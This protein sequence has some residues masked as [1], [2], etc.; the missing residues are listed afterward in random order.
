MC[1][2]TMNTYIIDPLLYLFHILSA[3]L[4]VSTVSSRNCFCIFGRSHSTW[5]CYI[6]LKFYFSE[7]IKWSNY[8]FSSLMTYMHESRT[9][10]TPQPRREREMCCNRRSPPNG[11]VLQR[12]PMAKATNEDSAL[13]LR[14]LVSGTAGL[15]GLLVGQ[16]I[17][18]LLEWLLSVL[19]IL[20]EIGGQ[21]TVQHLERGEGGLG[22][23][24]KGG[25]RARRRGEA[26][27]DASVL[28][29]LLRGG[30]RNDTSTT[31][32]RHE[33]DMHRATLAVDL[34][35]H[36]V[37]QADLAA[38]ITAA[39]GD[40]LHLGREDA[41]TDGV[42]HL[43]ARLDTETN[44]AV[45][46]ADEHEGLEA[47][48][49]T[50]RGLLLNGL[51]LENLVL[52]LASAGDAEEILHDLVLLDGHGEEEEMLERLDL[53]SLHKAAELGAGHPLLLVAGA[54][55]AAAAAATVTTTTVTAA[56]VATAT[57]I[58]T[59]ATSATVTAE[60]TPEASPVSHSSL[61][62]KCWENSCKILFIAVTR[63]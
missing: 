9:T 20:P 25:R 19:G 23:V 8:A 15:D 37:G 58:T 28:E 61:V 14:V 54:T 50:G 22:E 53:A 27:V 1:G 57:T 62:W 7:V 39:N 38:P 47:S 59:I 6:F 55:A 48:T 34:V 2:D 18:E 30:S 32:G 45:E 4:H 5:Q 63:V 41:T 13:S 51:H 35:G 17:G 60:A 12:Q 24:T 43:L 42:G 44:V 21:V 46:V 31:G 36:S 56:A 11:V 40:N 52:E 29:D 10:H 3:T 49:L 16:I 33:A 26:I